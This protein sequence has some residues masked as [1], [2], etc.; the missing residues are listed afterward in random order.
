MH[1]LTPYADMRA[2][3]TRA[4]DNPAEIFRDLRAW[5]ILVACLL[6]FSFMYGLSVWMPTF[7][8]QERGMGHQLSGLMSTVFFLGALLMRFISPLFFRR[9]QAER[10]YAV[11][12]ILSAACMSAA[13]TLGPALKLLIVF[14]VFAGGFLQGANTI[15]LVMI[16]CNRFPGRTASASAVTVL[17]FNL[18][19]LTMPLFIGYLAE[20]IGFMLPMYLLAL[21]MAA[22]VLV[23]LIERRV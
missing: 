17:A 11:S 22:S 19:A 1:P 13:F 21:C 15:A 2:I 12:G 16:S 23:I 20:R 6:Y 18:S 14:L 4:S 10:F 9:M 3:R 5:L 7:F 8:Q